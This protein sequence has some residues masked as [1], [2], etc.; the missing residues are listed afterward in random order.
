[1]TNLRRYR[2][3]VIWLGLL[4]GLSLIWF[5]FARNGNDTTSTTITQVV[6]DVRQGQVLKITQVEDSRE[7]TI[8]YVDS[9]RVE[10]VSRL[11]Q[12]TNIFDLLSDSGVDPATVQIDIKKAS[13]WGSIFGILGFLLPLIL[14]AGFIIFMMRQAQGSNSQAM[15]FGKSRARLFL[16]QSTDRHVR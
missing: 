6:E 10:G 7:L 1:M 14:I 5:T 11:P 9:E 3:G 4:V 12:D 2:P 13:S 8:K 15:Q 16:E